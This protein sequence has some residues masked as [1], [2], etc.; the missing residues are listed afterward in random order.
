MAASAFS[1]DFTENRSCSSRDTLYSLATISLVSPMFKY[2]LGWFL[3][4]SG[5]GTCLH[6]PIEIIDMLS[7]PPATIISA[8]PAVI[9]AEAM[10]I[11]S[12]PD[13]QYL[14]MVEPGTS[15]VS[16]DMSESMRPMLKP[17]SA[18]GKAFPT[19]TSSMR[20]CGICGKSASKCRMTVAAMSSGRVKRKLPLGA[21]PMGDR[22][23]PTIY[24]FM[25]LRFS[26]S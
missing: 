19:T 25:I 17:D 21:F 23:P 13:A 16:I 11:D 7:A 10:A 4:T 5:L 18:S 2:H 6:P 9:L 1:T 3:A 26:G 20:V 8:S 24:A 14:L 12:R 22:Y 15:T